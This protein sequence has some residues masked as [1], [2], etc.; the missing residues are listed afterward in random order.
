M[1]ET[2]MFNDGLYSQE[3]Y[4]WRRALKACRVQWSTKKE[5]IDLQT[6]AWLD[7][8]REDYGLELVFIEGGI[9]GVEIVDDEKFLVFRMRYL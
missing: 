4:A 9:A 6:E 1:M 5:L 7:D 8:L 2:I 3:R